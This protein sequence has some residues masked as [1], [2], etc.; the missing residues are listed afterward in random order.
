MPEIGELPVA[1]YPAKE[2]DPLFCWIPKPPFG[3]TIVA[4][5]AELLTKDGLL[6]S[7]NQHTAIQ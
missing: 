2:S 7:H 4:L 6:A 1:R 5:P 3:T